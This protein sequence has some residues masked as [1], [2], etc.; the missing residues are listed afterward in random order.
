MRAIRALLRTAGTFWLGVVV[1]IVLLRLVVERTGL[2]RVEPEADE[3]RLMLVADGIELK[4]RSTAFRGGGLVCI[5]GGAQIDLREAT[6]APGRS[7]LH[8]ACA[9]G[10]ANIVV[11]EGVRVTMTTTAV[12]GGSNKHVPD[13]EREDAPELHVEVLAIMGGANVTTADR[14]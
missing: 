11:P 2:N 5:M 14:D 9:M 8:V 10:G 3:L 7:T 13:P 4:A 12:M 6:F 1:A